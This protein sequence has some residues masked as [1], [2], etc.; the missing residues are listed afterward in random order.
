MDDPTRPK[1]LAS[2]PDSSRPV[3]NLGRPENPKPNCEAWPIGTQGEADCNPGSYYSLPI[4]WYY[5]CFFGVQVMSC[6]L[7]RSLSG[8]P[9][10]WGQFCNSEAKVLCCISENLVIK[11]SSRAL[12]SGTVYIVAD[13]SRHQVMHRS[14]SNLIFSCSKSILGL[15]PF[16]RGIPRMIS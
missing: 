10:F 16:N 3:L 2:R 4:G 7:L 14:L 6:H 8:N 12:V 1:L 13:L 5:F 11:F 9:C 15:C